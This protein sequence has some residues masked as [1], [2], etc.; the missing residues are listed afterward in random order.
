MRT[1][2][3][4]YIWS[5]LEDLG[6]DLEDDN[7]TSELAQTYIDNIDNKLNKYLNKTCTWGLILDDY[8]ETDCMNQVDLDDY[9]EI[10]PEYCPYCG[11]KIKIE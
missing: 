10:C 3:E 2:I 1:H 11:S 5:L 9:E 6:Y 7:I 4:Q 8:F